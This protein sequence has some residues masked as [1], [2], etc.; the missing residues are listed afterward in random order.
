M[1]RFRLKLEHTMLVSILDHF[2][3]SILIVLQKDHELLSK[4]IV[5][6]SHGKLLDVRDIRVELEAKLLCSDII[7]MVNIEAFMENENVSTLH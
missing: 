2:F 4:H 7:V 6:S 1:A 5:A 3:I